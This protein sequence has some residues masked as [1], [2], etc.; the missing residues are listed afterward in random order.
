MR[1]REGGNEEMYVARG[2]ARVFFVLG[3]RAF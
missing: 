1:K 2:V 3:G